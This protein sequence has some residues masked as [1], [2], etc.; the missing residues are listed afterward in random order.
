[1]C[2]RPLKAE[3]FFTLSKHHA[4]NWSRAGLGSR[5]YHIVFSSSF[6]IPAV[7]ATS[8]F[9]RTGSIPHRGTPS[10]EVRIRC[11]RISCNGSCSWSQSHSSRPIRRGLLNSH[12]PVASVELL[13]DTRSRERIRRLGMVAP[14]AHG[15]VMALRFSVSTVR[16]GWVSTANNLVDAECDHGS[17]TTLQCPPGLSCVSGGSETIAR[18]AAGGQESQPP[19]NPVHQDVVNTA[20]AEPTATA[21]VSPAASEFAV[22]V[23]PDR[24]SELALQSPSSASQ[25]SGVPPSTATAN[26]TSSDFAAS[27]A[28]SPAPKGGSASAP[29]YVIYTD[30]NEMGELPSAAQLKGFNRLMLAFW[31]TTRGAAAKASTWM[32]LGPAGQAAKRAE[33]NAAGISVMV[34]AF[35]ATGESWS[36]SVSIRRNS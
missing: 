17:W 36:S 11:G 13:G 27:T 28:I 33:Y 3:H 18:C 22:S 1:M 8:T 4:C 19:L 2:E 21:T 20:T 16:T 9:W 31:M 30:A 34:S 15:N 12:R 35:G 32:K 10:S 14:R 6:S 7:R 24:S 26:A 23:A 5:A 29:H 25:T